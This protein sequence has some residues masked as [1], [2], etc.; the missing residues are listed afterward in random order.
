[1]S[2]ET[3]TSVEAP[4]S[5]PAAPVPAPPPPEPAPEPDLTPAD[6]APGSPVMDVV[7]HVEVEAEAPA[8]PV[9]EE[10]EETQAAAEPE[11][12]AEAEPAPAKKKRAKAKPADEEPAEAPAN[13]AGAA[14]AADSTRKWYVVKVQSGR[15]DSIKR[16]IE[17]KVKIQG[18]E[19][20]FGRIEIPVEEVVEKKKVKAKVKDKKTGEM[21]TVYQEKNV[22]K[23]RKKFP[24]YLFAEVDFNDR[25][26]YLFR[27]TSGVG[28]FVGATQHRA[29]NPMSEHEVQSMLTGVAVK[30]GPKA[31]KVKVKLDFEKGDKVKIRD[32]AFSGMEGEV[33][34]ISEAKDATETPKVKVEVTI[35]G[36]P[37]EV[38]L[39][40]WQVDKA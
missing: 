18:L 24:G 23:K 14:V 37:V 8:E 27:E 20:F 33:K 19:E 26:L 29:P 4:A 22:T 5:E 9:A 2:D 31:G 30:G 40:Y 10:P 7:S 34:H 13:G 21:D 1:M 16:D 38:E 25:I 3:A 11:P 17:R 12:V 6:D 35:F 39:D 36:R 32:G 15:E 28:D